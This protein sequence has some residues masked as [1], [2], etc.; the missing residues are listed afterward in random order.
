MSPAYTGYTAYDDVYIIAD[1][2]K[3]AGSTD[4][5]KIVAAMEKTDF[6][7]TIGRIEF[8]GKDEIHAMGSRPARARHRPHPMAE[9][10]AGHGLAG[11]YANGTMAFPSFIKVKQAA[12]H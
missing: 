8:Y 9:R 3:R 1:A 11:G 12:Q 6:D 4:P 7:G 10:Q 2:I 5:D